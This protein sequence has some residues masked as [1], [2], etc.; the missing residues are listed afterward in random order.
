MKPQIRN[1]QKIAKNFLRPEIIKKIRSL[2]KEE[3]IAEA[4]K[5]SIISELKL[6]HHEIELKISRLEQQNFNIVYAKIKSARVP[7]KIKNFQVEYNNEEFYKL[8]NLLNEIKKEIENVRI[9]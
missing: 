5:F 1:L 9:R 8:S 3:E 6:Q 4:L 7:A 2:D